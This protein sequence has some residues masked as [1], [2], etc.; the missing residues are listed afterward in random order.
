MAALIAGL[1]FLLPTLRPV[2]DSDVWWHLKAGQA[3]LSGLPGAFRECWS[4]TAQGRPWLNHEWLAELAL[5]AA[6][7]VGGDA[8]LWLLMGLML[9]ATALLLYRAAR[10]E[11]LAPGLAVALIAL[12]AAAAGD[13]FLPR[14]QLFTYVGVA[15]VLERFGAARA[16][17]RCP[18]ELVAVQTLWTNAHGAVIGLGLTSLL[19]AGGALPDLAWRRR[20]LLALALAGASCLQPQGVLPLVD[21]V[22]QLAGG[23]LY[24]Q[25]VREWLPLLDPGQ[26]GLAQTPA[27]LLLVGVALALGGAGLVTAR[28]G[29]LGYA[30]LLVAAGLAPLAAVRNRDLLAMM[31]VP[32]VASLPLVRGWRAPRAASAAGLL[33]AIALLVIPAAGLLGYPRPAW[34]PGLVETG[35]P[36]GAVRFLEREAVGKSIFNVY[37]QGGYLIYYLAPGRRVF[38]DG[39]YFVYGE[40]LY[41]DY[42]EIRDGAP[43]ARARLDHAGADLLLLRYPAADGYMGLARAAMEWPE[44][45][46]VYWDDE[47]L[48]YARTGAATPAWF[49]DHAYATAHPLVTAAHGTDSAWWRSRMVNLVRE[50][51]RASGEAPGAIRPRL[52][53]AIALELGGRAGDAART[54]REILA[55]HPASRP[56]RDGLAR[57]RSAA[58]AGDLPDVPESD[59]RRDF[60][61]P[62]R[63]VFPVRPGSTDG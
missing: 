51:W 3:L 35:F 49:A 29:G 25:T 56:A 52:V 31:V 41:R 12:A 13:R 57:L 58:G 42:L 6:R 24:R 61:L 50:A 36:R 30:L 55:D 17:R 60:G 32:A 28:R 40:A 11:G 43:D 10:R 62:P 37:D 48:L 5:A 20:G 14:P 34:T 33:A 53:L 21:N 39:R 7:N 63:P 19:L 59:L 16:S 2:A 15:L 4:F 45:R 38:V 27:T 8:G 22:R 54:Y 18:W 9:T 26:R 1:A 23:G 44:W 46:L 47:S